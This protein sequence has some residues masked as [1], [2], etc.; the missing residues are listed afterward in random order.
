MWG[1]EKRQQYWLWTG[2]TDMRQGF[3]GLSGLVRRHMSGRDPLSGDAFIFLN[4]RRTHLKI[5]VWEDG[6][7]LLYYKRLESGT[8]ERP[9]TGIGGS[10]R[11]DELILMVQGVVLKGLQRRKRFVFS[12]GKQA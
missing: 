10:V 9:M 7:F 11:W 4:H 2:S 3:D 6:G 1:L 8:F 5:L 12:E